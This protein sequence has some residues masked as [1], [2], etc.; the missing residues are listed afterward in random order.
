MEDS[1]LSLCQGACEADTTSPATYIW[2]VIKRPIRQGDEHVALRALLSRVK[3]RAEEQGD[4]ALYK[5]VESVIIFSISFQVE[6]V[7]WK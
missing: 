6:S 2:R 1:L 7:L 4:C 3:E 5:L